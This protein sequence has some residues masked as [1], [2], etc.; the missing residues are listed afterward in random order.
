MS[1]PFILSDVPDVTP[2]I[3][4]IATNGQTVFPYPFPITQ[5]SDLVVVVNGVTLN[6]DSGYTLSGQGDDT[7]GN[8]TFTLGRTAG[9]IVTLFRDIQI[10]RVSQIAQNS[11]F[12][13]T[14]FNAEYNNIYLIL[15]QL[16]ASIAQCLQVPNTNNPA[17]VTT[18]TPANYA[19]KYQAYDAFGN[20]TPALLTSSGSITQALIVSLL[21]QAVIGGL[22]FPQTARESAVSV[23]P[24]NFAYSEG[25]FL[26]YGAVGDGV[27]NNY[28]AFQNAVKVCS[29]A[30][31]A[32]VVPEGNYVIDTTTGTTNLSY[33]T[34][35]GTGVLT[36]T[37]TPGAA[38]SVFSIT[39]TANS[40]FTI[41]PSV[42]FNGI[43]FLY[44]AQV[45]SFTPTV[46]PPTMVTSLAI[47][48]AI[49][50]V[51]IQNCVVFNAYRFFVNADTTGAIGHVFFLDNTIYGILTCY[52]GTYNAEIITFTGNE[53]T[54]GHFLTA[55]E[56]GLR[57]YTRANGSVLKIIRT[58]GITFAGNVAFGYQFGLNFV[59]SATICQ[60]TAITDN[61]FDQCLFPFIAS[62]TGNLS[63]ITIT[64]N[65]MNAFN[66]QSQIPATIGNCIKITTSGALVLE[67]V[68]I[69]SNIIGTC[70]GDAILVTGSTPPRSLL[71]N[72][73]QINGVGAF[74]TSGSFACANITGTSTSYQFTN[75]EC[76]N[77]AGT[78][79]VANGILGT[80]VDVVITGN[81]F[82]GYQTAI[83]A[84]FNAGTVVGNLSYGTLG[85]SANTY[86]GNP[87]VDLGNNWDKDAMK[88]TGWGTPVGGSVQNNF[89]AGS[90][91]TMAV[92]SAAVAEILVVLKAKNIIG[93]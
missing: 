55:T 12:S 8:V 70:N 61:V 9:D 91:Q 79:A 68:T 52:E 76:V 4:Y 59:T 42:T 50:F 29:S 15:Q 3:Q 31:L 33:I 38:G 81:V 6:T 82:G 62:G 85:T 2:Y 34:I 65:V 20:P 74:Q 49:N 30:G 1:V 25:N 40:P 78:A 73:N 53:F 32:L 45:D 24:S 75:N 92:I 14:V 57:K 88:T 13:S 93:A 10:Q 35:Q 63:N 72:G 58:D 36:G 21:S 22:L 80:P 26:R 44:P 87:P 77:Q 46:F 16:E 67:A 64:A 18:L 17:P 66:S 19:N 7:G 51:Y 37:T 86:G 56:T 43:G 90:G 28:T 39:G 27:T 23:V 60:L 84:T 83:N 89:T 47:A 41:G 54:F 69:A 5:D 48:G 71:I 11:G